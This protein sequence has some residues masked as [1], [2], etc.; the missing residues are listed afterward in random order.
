MKTKNSLQVF[1]TTGAVT[2]SLLLGATVA[3]AATVVVFGSLEGKAIGIT[4]LDIDGT[5]YEVLFDELATAASIYGPFPGTFSMTGNEA[6]A[7]SLA[8][9]A[10]LNTAEALSVGED[11]SEDSLLNGRFSIG[12][13]SFGGELP[14]TQFV[15]LSEG[16]FTLGEWTDP[17]SDQGFYVGEDR[18]WA[19]FTPTA[20]IPVPAAVWLFGSA[21]GLLGWI[22]K[23][24]TA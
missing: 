13:S 6:N 16:N 8:I 9:V 10:A 22:R 21:L 20:V 2:M 1:L 17:R 5:S 4:D 19:T 3:S 24:T 15:V 11:T 18:T 23:R 12:V 7:A 14:S